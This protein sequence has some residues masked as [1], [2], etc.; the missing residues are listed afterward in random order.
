MRPGINTGSRFML[1]EYA[2]GSQ[3][4]NQHPSPY[5]SLHIFDPGLRLIQITTG[6]VRELFYYNFATSLS[7]PHKTCTQGYPL[8]DP[9]VRK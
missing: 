3:Q 5:S 2:S 7:L 1:A 9:Y 6:S 8:L 4:N